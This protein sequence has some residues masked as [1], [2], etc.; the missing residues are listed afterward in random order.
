[1]ILKTIMLIAIALLVVL[2]VLIAMIIGNVVGAILGS[3]V[4]VWLCIIVV[5]YLLYRI[6]KK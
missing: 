5:L 3:E 6:A 1:M 2:L 4:M